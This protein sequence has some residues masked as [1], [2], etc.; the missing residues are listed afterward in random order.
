MLK[1]LISY[2]YCSKSAIEALLRIRDDCD[3]ILDS[4]AF[5]SYK[6]GRVITVDEYCQFL[7]KHQ[8][9]FSTRFQLDVIGDPEKTRENFELLCKRGFEV[10]PVWTRGASEADLQYYTSFGRVVGFGGLSSAGIT[11]DAAYVVYAASLAKKYG[12]RVHIFGA[13]QVEKLVRFTKPYSCDVSTITMTCRY[14]GMLVSSHVG[15]MEQHF[16]DLIRKRARI[17]ALVQASCEESE[18]PL[19]LDQK[20]WWGHRSLAQMISYREYLRYAD[21]L[22]KRTGMKLFAAITPTHISSLHEA[23]CW[24]KQHDGK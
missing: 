3:I 4:G 13:R 21:A 1:I 12:T 6:R 11:A 10:S 18:A 20:N 23:F 16:T 24:R 2:A 14:G 15:I 17:M 22:E 7:E 5:T 19:L 8:E 9:L